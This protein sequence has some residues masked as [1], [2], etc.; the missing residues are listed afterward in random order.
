MLKNTENNFSFSEI[1]KIIFPSLLAV[2]LFIISLFFVLLPASKE[3]LM[4]Q[5][6]IMT[7]TLVQTAWHTLDYYHQQ[8]VSGNLSMENAQDSAIQHL[9]SVRYG[10]D[11]K[12]YFWINDMGP[13]MIMHP[14]RPD[15][16]GQSLT[17]Y[18]DPNGKRPFIDMV[19]TAQ[20]SG[21]G[22]LPYLWQWNDEPEKIVAK[23]S[24]VKLFS[25]WEWIIG[26]GVYFDDVHSEIAKVTKRLTYISLVILLIIAFL[27]LYII[28]KGL[29]ERRR[30]RKAEAD[31]SNYQNH[32]EELVSQRTAEL[33]NA[34]KE[35]KKL[36]G[37][38]PI[39]ASCKKIRDDKG[40]WNQ[41]E[42]YIREHSEA[43]F[44]HGMCPECA[45]KY[46]PKY[47]K[48]IKNI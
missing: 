14:Y 23:V 37:Y 4:E 17:N 44:S 26:T 11:G 19:G 43:E 48:K 38:L 21:S 8:V 7:S 25:P 13:K 32:L 1:G 20:K 3:N 10:P 16:E 42:L 12:S 24:F 30:R 6:K 41:I 27:S 40:Y 28:N 2:V 5:K 15:L 33:E 47:A 9:R 31:V 22:F 36:S 29:A 45:K 35:V 34:L 46:Y 39:C 18:S